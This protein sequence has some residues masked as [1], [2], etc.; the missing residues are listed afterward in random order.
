MMDY[1]VVV[2]GAGPAGSMAAKH[3]ALNGAKTLLLEEHGQVGSPVS[4]TGHIS[5]KALEECELAEGHF[6]TKRIRGAYV[7]APNNRHIV[8][9]KKQTIVYV[10]ER[11]ILD[12]EMAR[13]AVSAGAE[14]AVSTR[15][16]GLRQVPG[17]VSLEISG[18]DGR[19]E[20]TASVVI[21]ADGVKSKIARAA[22]LGNLPHV[23]SGIQVEATYEPNDPEFVEMFSGSRYA[24]PPYF[25]WAVPTAGDC[26]RVGLL[27]DEHASEY[28]QRLLTEHE[29]VSKKA[30]SAVDL[31]VGGVPV[32]TL[33]R[34]VSD[35]VMIVG[36]AAG[37]V[38]PVSYG[39]IYTGTRSARIAGEV[40]ARAALGGDASAARLMEYERRWR[41]DIGR[42][43]GLMMR[44]RQMYGKMSDEDL[45][46]A[47]A[48]L[49]DPE[50]SEVM[51][52][53][54]DIDRPSQLAF[55]LLKLS[56]S[57]GMW[58]LM[59]LLARLLF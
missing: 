32:G 8:L 51:T 41:A 52:R 43:L 35:H 44:F 6:I 30:R 18:P 2:V 57:R 37:Q 12:R 15:A 45:N 36:D 50:V 20:V 34:T 47:L 22:G 56:R 27:A 4:C 40:A 5:R 11:K 9:D 46:E 24:P 39:G 13:R 38:K 55:E 14:I 58:R 49:D 17:G 28:L 42:E 21:G 19:S 53:Y 7:Y 33:K 29:I 48:L 54:G 10:V 1:D 3:A 59:G 31:V 26:C 25:A 23:C 16:D